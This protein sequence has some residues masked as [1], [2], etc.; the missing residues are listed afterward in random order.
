MELNSSQI[1]LITSAYSELHG[2]VRANQSLEH[3]ISFS[4]GG[5]FILFAAIVLR[6][7]LA[8]ITNYQNYEG[9]SF[10]IIVISLITM[11]F[12]VTNM[13]EMQWQCQRIVSC[14]KAMGMY[15]YG[16]FLKD[17]RIFPIEG[18]EWG[19][20]GLVFNSFPFLLGVGSSAAAAIIAL[21]VGLLEA[22]AQQDKGPEKQ[23]HI[24]LNIPAKSSDS[25]DPYAETQAPVLSPSS[26]DTQLHGNGLLEQQSLTALN[27]TIQ[28][29]NKTIDSLVPAVNSLVD[30]QAHPKPSSV[31][32]SPAPETPLP[33]G[34]PEIYSVS[35]D[36]GRL[37]LSAEARQTIE[38]I[39]KKIE[40]NARPVLCSGY[41]DAL[42]TPAAN[43][44][45]SIQR[46]AIVAIELVRK[47]VPVEKITVKGH[48]TH[49]EGRSVGIVVQ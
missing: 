47:G 9:I 5:L 46:A 15:R 32:P 31:L 11:W 17:E 14:E 22:K 2:E 7:Q 27:G 3:K 16:E 41:S 42:G 49:P 30:Q 21:C 38:Q 12:L 48:G 13:K 29:L 20:K 44:R 6:R 25:N 26:I 34:S 18:M 28:Q 45:L 39:A 19:K 36:S 24:S 37:D 23:N 35:F 40:A 10:F 1:N 43:M 8:F 4:V 33:S